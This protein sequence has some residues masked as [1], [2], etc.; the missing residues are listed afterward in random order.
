VQIPIA[1][2]AA[3]PQEIQRLLEERVQ[4]TPARR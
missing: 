1:F 4:M 3:S 2:L